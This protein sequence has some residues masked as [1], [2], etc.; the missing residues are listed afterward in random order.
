MNGTIDLALQSEPVLRPQPRTVRVVREHGAAVAAACAFIGVASLS[1]RSSAPAPEPSSAPAVAPSPIPAAAT[2]IAPDALTSYSPGGRAAA[3][4]EDGL[5]S[6]LL[7]RSVTPSELARAPVGEAPVSLGKIMPEA[8]GPSLA[9]KGSLSG[10]F[11]Y[12]AGDE[13][14]LRSILLS[15]KREI[16][17]LAK[18]EAPKPKPVAEKKDKAVAFSAPAAPSAPRRRTFRSATGGVR[19]ADV[20][21]NGII[22]SIVDAAGVVP[23]ASAADEPVVTGRTRDEIDYELSCEGTGRCG[24]E[25]YRGWRPEAQVKVFEMFAE[26]KQALFP[27]EVVDHNP[28]RPICRW[29]GTICRGADGKLFPVVDDI[30]ARRYGFPTESEIRAQGV[31]IHPSPL[32][33]D[34]DGDGVRTASRRV[35]Y[36]ING[37]GLRDRFTDLSSKDGLLVFD[38]DGDGISGE[39][40]RELLGTGT[41]LDGNGRS[42]GFANGFDALKAL[43]SKAGVAAK[44][45]W[46]DAAALAALETRVGLRV[47]VGGLNAKAIS[48][49]EAG[50]ARLRLSA[51]EPVRVA[52]FDGQGNDTMRQAGARFERLD[53]SQGDY[54]DVWFRARTPVDLLARR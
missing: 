26:N 28:G 14:G 3:G 12:A 30:T 10:L 33:L 43:A 9:L 23:A 44:D 11:A 6:M 20:V 5:T 29:A 49:K 15:K 40:A 2:E 18:H 41:D 27:K 7:E 21:A 42:D 8:M 45:G 48:L 38:A 39:H 37:D 19:Q 24:L 50:V 47:R 34:L 46:L 32:V 36:D 17:M 25:T 22:Y 54:E 13:D 53:G 51:S 1:L 52:D 4:E 35:R 16:W 31:E